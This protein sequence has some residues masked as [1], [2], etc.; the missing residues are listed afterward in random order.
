MKVSVIIPVYNGEA[1]IRNCIDRLKKESY[2]NFEV[3]VV[4][5]GS[6]D[7]TKAIMMEILDENRQGGL[8]IRFINRENGGAAAAR[9]SALEMAS[10]DAIMFLDCDDMMEE[11]CIVKLVTA[12]EKNSVDIVRF[13]LCYSYPDGSVRTGKAEYLNR[14]I[15][16]KGE[17]YENIY[18][19]MMSGVRYNHIVR[20]LYHRSVIEGIRFRTDLR[21]AEDLCFNV[22]AFT[23]ARRYMYLPDVMYYY[24]C[25]GTGLT[26]N[27]LGGIEKIK[28]NLVAA[29]EIKKSLYAWGC[30]NVLSKIRTDTRIVRVM[31]RKIFRAFV[32]TDAF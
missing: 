29:K 21:T 15:I 27:A 30:D 20:T 8:N 32:E 11:D 28:C 24:Y 10:G 12:M 18:K 26:G 3:I 1:Y 22:Q 6:T 13:R 17:F 7:S 9:N 25:S 31:A 14:R 5:D 2:D 23:R 4:N 19:P 16:S